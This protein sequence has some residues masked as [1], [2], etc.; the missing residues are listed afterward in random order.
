MSYLKSYWN[1][2]GKCFDVAA[3]IFFLISVFSNNALATYFL[4]IAM[5]VALAG[6]IS[7]A[8]NNK[9]KSS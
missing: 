7:D 6:P 3:V 8:L 1:A 4:W 2:Y 5:V 9:G